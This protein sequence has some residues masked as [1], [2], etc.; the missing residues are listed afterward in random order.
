MSPPPQAPKGLADAKPKAPLPPRRREG[1]CREAVSKSAEETESHAAAAQQAQLAGASPTTLEALHR[2][3]GVSVATLE[4]LAA[5]D[6]FRSFR[7]DR[8]QALWQVRA[9]VRAPELP[10]FA[11]AAARELGSEP[12]TQLPLMPLPEHVVADYQTLRLSLKA[13]PMSFLRAAFEAEGVIDAAALRDVKDGQRVAYAGIVLVRQRPGSAKGVVFMTLEDEMGIANSVVWP[14]MLER[15]RKVVMAARLI[16]VKG[17]VQRHQDIIHIVAQYLEDR[18]HWLRRLADGGPALKV[19]VAN[20]DGVVRPEPDSAHA[21]A[22]DGHPRLAR[23][24]R[25]IRI[26]PPSRDFH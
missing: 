15:F 26:L 16:L 13:H 14:K 23:H 22:G 24:P 10:L 2:R 18:S 20:A 8:R 25:N 5:A 1:E 11:Y 7:L 17:V 9:L 6:A 3:S 21:A 4:R 19:P 12:E